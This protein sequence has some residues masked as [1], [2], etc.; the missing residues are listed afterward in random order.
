MDSPD[1][2]PNKPERD[3]GFP[4]GRKVGDGTPGPGRPKGK[5]MGR[6]LLCYRIDHFINLLEK[7]DELTKAFRE[8][9]EKDPKWFITKI[10]MPYLS[11]KHVERVKT[12]LEHMKDKID[13]S[14]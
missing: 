7:K 13:E 4:K 11:I 12:F 6:T 5:P 14:S 9:W 3:T 10:L 2:E 8:L 1:T